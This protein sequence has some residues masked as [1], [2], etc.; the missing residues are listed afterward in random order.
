MEAVNLPDEERLFDADYRYRN[1][2]REELQVKPRA[3]RVPSM[4]P[5]TVA[6]SLTFSSRCRA[7]DSPKLSACCGRP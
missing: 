7:V 6:A 3:G 5:K 1:W 2:Y 4:R